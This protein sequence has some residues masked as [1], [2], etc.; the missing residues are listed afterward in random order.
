MRESLRKLIRI[1]WGI[2]AAGLVAALCAYAR[3]GSYMRFIGDDYCYGMVLNQRG[4]WQAQWYSYIIPTPYTGDRFSLTFFSDV[5][6]TLGPGFYGWLAGLSLIV[7]LAGLMTLAWQASSMLKTSINPLVWLTGTAGFAFLI[8]YQAPDLAESF[9]WRSGMLPYFMPLVGD[10]W[11]AAWLLRLI[12]RTHIGRSELLGV[13]V[14][15]FVNAGFSETAVAL[16]A[17]GL[18]LGLMFTLFVS[19]KSS[20]LQIG[21]KPVLAALLG[22]GVGMA[23]MLI[24]PSNAARMDTLP[25]SLGFAASVGYSLKYATDFI[26]ETLKGLPVPTLVGLAFSIA[27]GFELV[28]DSQKFPKISLRDWAIWTVLILA[29]GYALVVCS[30]APSVFIQTWYPEPRALIVA[31]FALELT[32]FGLGMLSGGF[33]RGISTSMKGLPA[34]RFATAFLVVSC[35]VYVLRGAVPILADLTD[36]QQYAAQWDQR[37]AQIRQ[38]RDDGIRDV[39]VKHLPHLL[40]QIGDI[41]EDAGHWYNNCAAGYYGINSIRSVP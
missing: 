11:L 26:Y 5:F 15:A 6:H 28:S 27:L 22:T 16:Q 19:R 21:W 13:G 14:L 2:A 20:R 17:G 23:V 39:E 30:M 8:L 4:F 35:A 1:V 32:L 37:D 33:L 10:T 40:L 36:F 12:R 41:S 24:S 9:Y 7:W 34:A 31:R 3:L 29:A 38:N 25:E 18:G